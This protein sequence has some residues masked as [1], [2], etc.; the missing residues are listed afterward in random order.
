M[1]NDSQSWLAFPTHDNTCSLYYAIRVLKIA[2]DRD[3]LHTI[4]RVE[5]LPEEMTFFRTGGRKW[6][7][8]ISSISS[9]EDLE[10]SGR[11]GRK[12]NKWNITNI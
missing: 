8:L 12:W 5:F 3:F 11:F 7:K 4:S 2:T 1:Y 6:K 10:E 9:A